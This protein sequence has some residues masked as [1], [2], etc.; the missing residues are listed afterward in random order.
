MAKPSPKSPGV[1]AALE[2]VS[3]SLY[4]RSRLACIRN[5]TCVMCGSRAKEFRDDLSRREFAISSL[6]QKCQD[7]TFG[8]RGATAMAEKG[9]SRCPICCS[10]LIY[11]GSNWC[12][13]NC[14]YKSPSEVAGK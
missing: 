1:E 2:R 9:T 3:T 12:C 10:S 14:R 7:E 5:D 4:G 8:R 13:P 6:C 11:D